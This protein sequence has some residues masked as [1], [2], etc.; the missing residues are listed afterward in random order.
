MIR[1]LVISQ[2]LFLALTGP[3]WAQVQRVVDIPTRPGVTQRFIFIQP[4]KPK[5]AVM[6]YPGGPGGQGGLQITS[7]GRFKGE[8]PMGNFLQRARQMFASKGLMVALVDAPSDRQNPPYL[9]GGFRVKPMHAADA[10]FL[11]AWL[12]KQA[13]VP[14]WLIG[15]C[16]G[17]FSAASIAARLAPANGGPDGLVLTSTQ[18]TNEPGKRGV[19]ELPGLVKIEIPT[20]V[21]HHKLDGCA[22]CKPAGL[23]HLMERLTAASRKELILVEG[24]KNEGN[25]CETLA[26]HGFNGIEREVADRIAEWI[27]RK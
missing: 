11:I 17:T 1:Y 25:P 22:H 21:V 4:E 8:G 7:S 3:V 16:S 9:G 12:K 13:N 23:S 5:A 26:Y 24:G 18:L 27:T 6:L 10:K 20:L 15:N 19:S 2:I 14:V